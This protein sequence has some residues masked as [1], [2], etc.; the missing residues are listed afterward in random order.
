MF[1]V[2]TRID[3]SHVVPYLCSLAELQL[4]VVFVRVF[5]TV[6]AIC[7]GISAA[8]DVHVLQFRAARSSLCHPFALVILFFI[9]VSLLMLPHDAPAFLHISNGSII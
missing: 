3:Q 6:Y 9:S 4:V 5:V 8:M 1:F 7:H 2:F